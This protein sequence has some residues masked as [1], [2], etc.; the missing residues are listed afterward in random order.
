MYVINCQICDIWLSW[1]LKDLYSLLHK[2]Q[3]RLKA[4]FT[5]G[6]FWPSGI[7]VTCVWC[8]MC[9]CVRFVKI[10]IVFRGD[11]PWSSRSNLTWCSVSPL[12]K[13]TLATGE[14]TWQPWLHRLI[15]GPD[16][17][18]FSIFSKYLYNY[19]APWSRLFYSLDL[20]HEYQSRQ[21]GVPRRLTPLLFYMQCCGTVVK[22]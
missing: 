17:F 14:N 8:H 13:K 10:P 11:W 2:R 4:Y 15:H 9:P 5:R 19:T 6:Q 3:I 1:A 7:V 20:Q 21:Q 18:T 16:C 22:T 12:D